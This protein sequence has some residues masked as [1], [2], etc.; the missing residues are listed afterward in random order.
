MA[1]AIGMVSDFGGC[2]T[3]RAKLPLIDWI[4]WIAFQFFREAHFRHAARSIPEDFDITRHHAHAH[5]ARSRT[6]RTNTRLPYGEARYE[7][8]F[9]N[10]SDEVIVGVAA[11]RE[12]GAGTR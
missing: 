7:V 3:S 6:Q 8:L 12:R 10:V 4:L 2:L 9:R 11:T 5:A 1:N